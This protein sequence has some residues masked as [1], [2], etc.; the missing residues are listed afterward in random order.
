MTTQRRH[1]GFSFVKR[2]SLFTVTAA[3]LLL[4]CNAYAGS[5]PLMRNVDEPELA[6]LAALKNPRLSAVVQ[7][8]EK[9]D[10]V[11]RCLNLSLPLARNPFN[12]NIGMQN[13]I[14]HTHL[15]VDPRGKGVMVKL[16]I[17]F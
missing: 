7:L 8:D 11:V 15:Q 17:S 1:S 10:L 13:I 6:K 16:E 14:Q 3:I 5:F 12:D 4:A 9:G 2:L